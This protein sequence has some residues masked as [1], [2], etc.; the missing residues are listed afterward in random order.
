MLKYAARVVEGLEIPD[1]LPEF[2]AHAYPKSLSPIVLEEEGRRVVQL[3]RWGVSYAVKGKPT[4]VTNARDDQLLRIALWKESV[5]RRRC[6]V[7]VVGYFE[8]GL[9]PVGMKGEI[10]FTLR[11]RPAFFIAGLWDSDPDGSRAFSMVT[12]VPNEYTKPFQD[13]QPVVLSDADAQ[14]WL[15][16]H[17]LPPD[18]VFALTRPPPNEVMQHE[19]IPAAPRPKKVPVPG[20]ETTGQL[21]LGV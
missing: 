13:R 8:P 18:R 3:H 14:A 11:D 6:L 12:T 4:F 16:S 21:D 20:V 2:T 1:P 19:V 7:P 9:G 5:T 10:L 15:G 17:P